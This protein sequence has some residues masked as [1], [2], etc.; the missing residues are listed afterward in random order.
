MNAI[1]LDIG[2]RRVGIARSDETGILPVPHGVYR[3]RNF[4][5]DVRALAEVCQ[6]L[7]AEVLVVGLPLNMDGSEGPQVRKV[8]ELAEAVAF[9]ANLPLV[10]VDERWTTK[11]VER[12]LRELGDN[13]RASKERVDALSAVLILQAWLE[14][15]RVV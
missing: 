5:E 8:K 15:Q 4:A 12:A 10:Y 9:A 2:E 1:A 7:R 3:R 13:L 14:R 11:E 6:S